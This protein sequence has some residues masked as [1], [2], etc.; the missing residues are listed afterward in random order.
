MARQ[1]AIGSI[2]GIKGIPA[3]HVGGAIIPPGDALPAGT[4]EFDLTYWYYPTPADI[5]AGA[6]PGERIMVFIPGVSVNDSAADIRRDILGERAQ[7][8]DTHTWGT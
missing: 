6:T 2:P 5:A 7:A 4:R 1:Y 8:R 3:T